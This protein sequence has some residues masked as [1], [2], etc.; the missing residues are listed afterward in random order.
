MNSKTRSSEYPVIKTVSEQISLQ[1]ARSYIHIHNNTK[2]QRGTRRLKFIQVRHTNDNPLPVS[3]VVPRRFGRA[4]VG[5]C[6]QCM[7]EDGIAKRSPPTLL[8]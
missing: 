6:Q 8:S 7:P 1:V 5:A 4:G 3:V 2:M